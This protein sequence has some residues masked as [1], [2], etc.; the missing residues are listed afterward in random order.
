MFSFSSLLTPAS[1]GCY[2]TEGLGGSE[3]AQHVTGHL[4]VTCPP[5][6]QRKNIDAH[7]DKGFPSWG[8]LSWLGKEEVATH[9][10]LLLLNK[11]I[12]GSRSNDA[13]GLQPIL[14]T[15]R[16]L[17]QRCLER[18]RPRSPKYTCGTY[19]QPSRVDKG[20]TA[21]SL[22]SQP[23]F[24]FYDSDIQ[25]GVKTCGIKDLELP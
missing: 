3:P 14:L 5:P 18:P 16:A 15:H 8:Y 9:K 2:S 22:V 10:S 23:S 21:L 12:P 19:Q 20:G 24:I 4:H 7:T 17:E 11:A 1:W 13:M 6:H 25:R